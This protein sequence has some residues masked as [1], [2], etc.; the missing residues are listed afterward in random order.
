MQSVLRKDLLDTHTH[1]QRLSL[2][3]SSSLTH[4][5]AGSVCLPWKQ[6]RKETQPAQQSQP[7]SLITVNHLFRCHHTLRLCR[8]FLPFFYLF[9]SVI[10]VYY[11]NPSNA[12]F[13]NYLWTFVVFLF[14]PLVSLNIQVAALDIRLWFPNFAIFC[15]F[16]LR[17][18]CVF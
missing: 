1:T 13:L 14:A 5:F 15:S 16:N 3:P 12:F 6:T 2:F 8:M 9:L 11:C 7:L 10:C 4:K 17:L 18:L